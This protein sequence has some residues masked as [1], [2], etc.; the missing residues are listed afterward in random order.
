MM[1]CFS[2]S[3]LVI[4]A[5][6]EPEFRIERRVDMVELGDGRKEGGKSSN[7]WSFVEAKG[8]ACVPVAVCSNGA[9]LGVVCPIQQGV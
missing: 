7:F 2:A 9:H 5:S 4:E 1:Y 6:N 8:E 3:L